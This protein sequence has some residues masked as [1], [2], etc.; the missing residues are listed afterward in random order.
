MITADELATIADKSDQLIINTEY[1]RIDEL[2]V[3]A[4]KKGRRSLAIKLNKNLST[5]QRYR[6]LEKFYT[7][8]FNVHIHK[9]N[10]DILRLNWSLV[11]GETE[12]RVIEELD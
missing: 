6:I 10:L 11:I 4:A 12:L 9:L 1:K 2:L 8:G 3:E 7:R 5:F